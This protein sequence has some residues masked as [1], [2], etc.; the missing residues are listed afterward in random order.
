[1]WGPRNVVVS[2]VVAL[3]VL[4]S[5]SAFTDHAART[6]A[7]TLTP[8]AQHVGEERLRTDSIALMLAGV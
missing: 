7:A 6:T 8:S 3:S 1:M 5:T 2:L 4:L